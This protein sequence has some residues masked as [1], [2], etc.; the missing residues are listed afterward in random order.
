MKAEITIKG[1]DLLAEN[2]GRV[3]A[4]LEANKIELYPLVNENGKSIKK[5]IKD[6]RVSNLVSTVAGRMG[7]STKEVRS[8]LLTTFKP[9]KKNDMYYVT[10]EDAYKF[11]SLFYKANRPRIA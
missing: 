8:I 10:G 9:F 7:R 11:R 4:A 1:L 6:V 2:I 3:A 5:E